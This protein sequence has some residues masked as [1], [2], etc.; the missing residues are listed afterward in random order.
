MQQ[1]NVLSTYIVNGKVSPSFP[2]AKDQVAQSDR[3]MKAPFLP[4]FTP[5]FNAPFQNHNYQQPQGAN[6]E[7]LDYAILGSV[8]GKTLSLRIPSVC[9]HSLTDQPNNMY[10][11][12]VLTRTP[13]R[14]PGSSS[15]SSV[16]N[17]SLSL[18]WEPGRPHLPIFTVFFL[19]PNTNTSNT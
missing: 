3:E 19:L 1:I 9:H 8:R 2:P 14:I 16:V 6:L 15:S 18:N 11:N 17:L 7:R 13:H 10:C 5:P 4:F 12:A